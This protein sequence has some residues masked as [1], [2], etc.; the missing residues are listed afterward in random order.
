MD[1]G[2]GPPDLN[3]LKDPPQDAKKEPFITIGGYVE[4]VNIYYFIINIILLYKLI[5]NQ[6]CIY[7]NIYSCTIFHY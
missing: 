2:L 7:N 4:K 1:S 5:L 6:T 3:L